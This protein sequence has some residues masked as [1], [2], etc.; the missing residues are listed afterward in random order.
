[1]R[2]APEQSKRET[3]VLGACSE[4][5]RDEYSRFRIVLGAVLD[6]DFSEF[7]V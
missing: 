7:R 4:H 3:F 2:P 1:L 5:R 6:L